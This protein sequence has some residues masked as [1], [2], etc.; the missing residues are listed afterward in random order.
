MK[1][2]TI[3]IMAILVIGLATAGVL[4]YFGQ[5]TTT[6]NVEQAVTLL[7]SETHTIEEAAPGGERFCFLHKVINDASIDIDLDFTQ[8]CKKDQA[9]NDCSGI[10]QGVYEIPETTELVLC[11][12]DENWQCVGEGKEATLTFNTVDTEF[13][14]DLDGT[15]LNEI[16]YAIVYYLDINSD[17]DW[18]PTNVVVVDTFTGGSIVTGSVDIGMNM[19][20]SSDYNKNPIPDY[21][22]LH[23]TFDDY[24]HCKGAKLWIVPTTDIT[25][26]DLNKW[27]PSNWLFETDLIVYADCNEEPMNF[28]VDMEMGEQAEPI[29]TESREITPMLLCYDFDVMIDSGLYEITT[30]VVPTE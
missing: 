22:G 27:N 29:T 8:D 1:K 2:I 25:D 24:E 16:E 18:N 12:K 13:N 19:P 20:V 26:N 3:G 7:G 15:E 30:K 21:C 28:A 9:W 10:V 4:Q 6:A 11:E 23:N 17:K 14:Y 5:I